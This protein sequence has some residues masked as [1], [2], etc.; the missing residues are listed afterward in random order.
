[1]KDAHTALAECCVRFL[2]FFDNGGSVTTDRIQTDDKDAF[3]EY[4]AMSWG[5]YL[6]E[7]RICD[8]AGAAIAPLTFRLS[9]PDTKFYALWSRIY[10]KK[11]YLKDPKFST[12][13]MVACFFGHVAVAKWSLEEGADVNAQ[14]GEYG[15]ALQ[16]ASSGDHEKVVRLLV[17][18]GA[19]GKAQAG[20]SIENN[21]KR[22]RLK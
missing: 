19:D 17:D 3:L 9:Q 20:C 4:S 22:I 18:K 12:R 6:R 15:N 8:D 21:R 14:G 10:W 16:A 2:S 1:M 7:S 5:L 11:K 13:L